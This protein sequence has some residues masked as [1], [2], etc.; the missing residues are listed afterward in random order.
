MPSAAAQEQ[1]S[2]SV[3]NAALTTIAVHTGRLNLTQK[4]PAAIPN[5]AAA[6]RQANTAIIIHL[7]R[8]RIFIVAPF[9]AIGSDG[10]ERRFLTDCAARA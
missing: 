3:E 8:A 2:A 7:K 9:P 6:Q 5:H 1:N 4:I 10:F